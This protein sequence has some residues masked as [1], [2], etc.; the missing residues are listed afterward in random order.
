[1]PVLLAQSAMAGGEYAAAL[2]LYNKKQYPAAASYFE[3]ASLANPSN[4]SA[5][6]Y[7]GY[8][9]YLAGRKAEA[10]KSFWRLANAYPTRREGIQARDFL[11]R[12]DPDFAKNDGA[13]AQ[14][15]AAVTASAPAKKVTARAVVDA[16]VQVK[17]G[18]GKLANCTPEF[19]AKIKEML[20]AMPLPILKFWLAQGGS[21]LIAPSVVEHDMRIQN[22][23]PRGWGDGYDWKNSPALTHGTQV[24]I[25][26]YR[27]DSRT[28]EYVD[29]SEE[30]GVIRHEAGHAIDH[31]LGDYTESG[32]FKHAYLLDVAKVPDEYRQRLDYFLQKADSG[33]SETFAELFCFHMGG[34]TA[35]RVEICELAHKYFP[36]ADKEVQKQLAKF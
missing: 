25:G 20:V 4:V 8:S 1:M 19:V 28:N 2:D 15:A 30:I 23:M 36:L 6:Y 27:L 21:V 29:T 22:T 34:E 18:T 35:N 32:D 7:A 5:T 16:L 31:C 11:K 14:P 10:I 13:A 24:V 9:F 33:P 17:P 12:L 3:A 26:Q